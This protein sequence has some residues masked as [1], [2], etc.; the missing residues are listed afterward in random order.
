[1]V[2]LVAVG[3]LL[4]SPG[5]ALA[6]GGQI[7]GRVT[8][9]ASSLGVGSV[10]VDV[11]DAGQ[12][13]VTSTQT[14]ADGTYTVSGLV[15]GTYEVGFVP[16]SG[17][18]LSQFFD[19]ETSLAAADAVPVTAGATTLGINAALAPGG[20]ISGTVTDAS[21]QGI[22]NVEVDVYDA[23]QNFVTS[24]MT[25]AD[26]T[27]ALSGL[28]T[29]RYE[30]GV[31]SSGVYASQFYNGKASLATADAVPVTAASPPTTVDL[32]LLAGA[33]ISGIV[34]DTAAPAN[35]VPGVEVDVYDASG[36]FV[37]S[38]QT[39]GDGTYTLSGLFPASY[40]IGFV[41]TSV[42]YA[43]QFNG[44]AASLAA[45]NPVA[46]PAGG[47]KTVDA[48]L[49]AGGQIA[50]TV[51]DASSAALLGRVRVAVYDSSGTVIASATTASDGTY[52]VLGIAP[53]SYNV[54]FFPGGPYAVQF[55]PGR[56]S[57]SAA[58][59]IAV[60]AGATTQGIDAALQPP[61]ST[62]SVV[63][64]GTGSGTVTGTGIGCPGACSQSYTTDTSVTLTASA[65]AGSTFA[66][67][68]GGGCGTASVCTVALSS[69]LALTA[70]FSANPPAPSPPSNTVL[71]SVSGNTTTGRTLSAHTGSWSGT[72]PLVYAY[73][74]QRCSPGCGN[75]TGATGSSY[76]LAAADT[77]ARILVV[78]TASNAAGR[79][80]SRSASVGPVGPSVAQI[81][82]LLST[83]LV[84]TGKPARIAAILRAGGYTSAVKA[85]AAGREE[86]RWYLVPPGAHLTK[87]KAPKPVLVA[88]GQL[89]FPRA[90]SG[91][92]KVK[93]SAAGRHD[94]KRAQRITL[95]AKASFALTGKA[96]V[97][98]IK[99]FRLRR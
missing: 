34:T 54:G 71:P 68:S 47:T 96:S 5:H 3:F 35:P 42:G 9:A 32:A 52:T 30:V 74:W 8:D 66:G 56:A 86:I 37:A 25:A 24:T 78:V 84:P 26:G 16:T 46:V 85:L 88:T 89:L 55:Y 72:P 61:T 7:S 43:A 94:L 36:N 77:G 10:D 62:L 31:P 29:G 21:S 81:K 70:D 63:L 11:Y 49:V 45:A 57:R 83:V 73:Q 39:G 15:T 12:N 4:A 79:T 98:V 40:K 38:T 80:S 23:S 91:K 13:F 59:A 58:D 95:S 97:S 14:G 20:Q 92:L 75:I 67:W 6:A 76:R 27:Y 99:R 1:M 53:G 48:A 82:S 44:G 64:A 17:N 41:P 60:T 65:A 33:Q 22:G 18:Y 2:V 90:G 51:T 93:L 19:G 50:G 28:A 69:S 87:G